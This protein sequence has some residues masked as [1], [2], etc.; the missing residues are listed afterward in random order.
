MK[1]AFRFVSLFLSLLMILTCFSGLT[2]VASAA[3][4]EEI[5]Y[6]DQQIAL[7]AGGQ[8]GAHGSY[9]NGE[10]VAVRYTIPE[11]DT[12]NYFFF[13]A[14]AT[15]SDANTNLK[16]SVYQWNTDYATTVAGEAICSVESAPHAD[17]APLQINVPEGVTVTGEV[18]L[19]L[20][21]SSTEEG[22]Q[23][24]PWA[25]SEGG[26][27]G[28]TYYA[29]GSECSAFCV[30][31]NVRTIES[32]TRNEQVALFNGGQGNPHGAYKN[33]ESVAVRYTIPEGAT[34]NYFFFHAVATY[35]QP[36]TDLKA[37]VYQWNTDY[38]TTV[39]GEALFSV[40][41]KNHADNAPLQIN[42][43]EGVTVTGEILLVLENTSAAEGKTMTPW[44]A[45]EGAADGVTFYANGAEASAFC[46]YANIRATFL[47]QPPDPA[48]SQMESTFT[49]DFGVYSDDPVTDY[50]MAHMNA[51]AAFD[52]MNSG[53]ITFKANGG[54]PWTWL[55]NADMAGFKALNTKVVDFAVI[56][57]RTTA[58]AT[59]EFYVSR[60]DGVS[61]GQAGSHASWNYVPDGQ[62]HTIVVDCSEVWGNTDTKITTLRLDPLAGDVDGK[63]IDIAS[64]TFFSNKA[65]AE[66]YAEAQKVVVPVKG[67]LI[68]GD[69]AVFQIGDSFFTADKWFELIENLV[70]VE[71]V[72]GDYTAM[73]GTMSSDTLF[74]TPVGEGEK[75]LQDGN[76]Q[77]YIANTLGGVISAAEYSSFAVRGWYGSPTE[78]AIEA[79]G[80]AFGDGEPVFSADFIN[81]AE[82]AVKGAAGT[83]DATRYK[84]NIDISGLA[85]GT[86]DV[87]VL[88]KH[89]NGNVFEL[90]N[91]GDIKV[92][93][94]DGKNYQSMGFV[95]AEGNA[96]T[97]ENG[98]VFN[99]EGIDTGLYAA[100]LADGRTVAYG[101]LINLTY[102]DPLAGAVEIDG[103]KYIY[104]QKIQVTDVMVPV[105][106]EDNSVVTSIDVPNVP[107]MSPDTLYLDGTVVKDG[108][109][110]DYIAK[111]LG[112]KIRDTD[113]TMG[114]FS[115]RGWAH[116]G[117]TT[118]IVAYGYALNDGDIIWDAGWVES[119]T[120]VSNVFPNTNVMRYMI[121]ID[122]SSLEEG[123]YNVYLYMKLEDESIYRLNVWGDFQFVKGGTWNH[124]G[125]T[126]G[127]NTYDADSLIYT[128]GDTKYVLTNPKDVTDGLVAGYDYDTLIESVDIDF[129]T[130]IES[131]NR[132]KELTGMD[133]LTTWPAAGYDVDGTQMMAMYGDTSYVLFSSLPFAEYNTVEIVIGT[134]TGVAKNIAVGFISD[135]TQ[136]YGMDVNNLNLTANIAYGIAGPASEGEPNL[137][138]RGNGGGWNS[139]ERLI[140]I[141]IGDIDYDGEVALSISTT[142][143][144]IAVITKLSFANYAT[145][146][147]KGKYIYDET[148]TYVASP[149]TPVNPHTLKPVYIVDGEAL[150]T[151]GG[152]RVEDAVYDYEKGC[153]RYTATD[154]DPNSTSNLVP[155]GTQIGRYLVVKYR[156][157]TPASGE[158]FT[159]VGAGASG[160]S[161]VPF[162]DYEADGQ[163]HYKVV[164]LSRSGDMDGTYVV[165][166]F[167]NDFVQGGGQWLEVEYYAF[168]NTVEEAE[169]YAS[170]DMHV[171]PQPPKYFTATFVADGEV[172]GTIEFKEGTTKLTGIPK[173]PAK[174][175]YTGAW[176]EYTLAD[177]DITINAVYTA[178]QEETVPETQ[179]GGEE[180]EAPK[181]QF[182]SVAHLTGFFKDAHKSYVSVEQCTPTYNE[183]GSLTL[184]G[185]WKED[186]GTI[187]P[188]VS[189]TYCQLMSKNYVNYGAEYG[190]MSKLPNAN[191]EFG[192]VVLKV[193]A[194]AAC[195]GSDLTL[196]Y[197][198][199]RTRDSSYVYSEKAL[200]GNGEFEYVLFDLTDED[201][202]K[203]DFINTLKI[204]WISDGESTAENVGAS[205]TIYDLYLFAD[206]AAA[207]AALE[208]QWPEKETKPPKQTTAE[209]VTT[210]PE[211]P[212][213]EGEETTAETKEG[214]KSV[215]AASGS[216]ALLLVAG[217][218]FVAT[219]K[220]KED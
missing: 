199:G 61:M 207:E 101:H 65:A 15:Y 6:K 142:D 198:M 193:K 163:W 160:G 50:G 216:I 162:G 112:G 78:G 33:G 31:V 86:Y 125:Y 186:A 94:G 208:I 210:A 24:T 68:E 60:A 29:N 103:R 21:N 203:S 84:I 3:G 42:V 10:S 107:A 106:P 38:A 56:K 28:V 133:V 156:T 113:K 182:D 129:A 120:S 154:N 209:P 194:D 96:Y 5:Q 14:V 49:I 164:D 140:R 141:N 54:D 152:Q 18:L 123:I 99:A 176:E 20:E 77:S 206:K 70:E 191:G 87:S 1:K 85:S 118:P 220:K 157:E 7:F 187:N 117:S 149:K 40:E 195:A 190:E 170:H 22:K 158:C 138:G 211:A 4:D 197:I 17:N 55:D 88:V 155:A 11:G 127:T 83:Q 200:V 53:Y 168:F 2:I 69:P 165:N 90:I 81:A 151:N 73:S 92:V 110:H 121:S 189:F 215:V 202:F 205:L 116:T 148:L 188:S 48:E 171:L 183:D 119:D 95:D 19:V 214:C 37:T 46:V 58:E 35:G 201:I 109:A 146:K 143:G 72:T 97:I 175:G 126:D 204:T 44:G 173:V 45:S 192:V 66:A 23:M 39:A 177:A 93:V 145:E 136:L 185:N 150:N 172:V 104:D 12:L 137:S 36:D 212:T 108:G 41:D 161:N 181:G 130:A 91:W 79:Y 76:A 180:T 8:G 75:T 26:V 59:G 124:I 144:N 147:V 16:A 178:K 32:I 179:P 217:A 27:E 102:Q 169:Y 166:H 131:A 213:G 25:A 30:Y 71:P 174:E 51:L 34:L 218:A 139:T 52:T 64:I 153:I 134:D 111:V 135:K 74:V 114:S 62:W 98:R 122:V 47:P 89:T 159:G 167:R 115:V 67:E 105:D 43:P 128:E 132:N 184:T 13:H 219:K 196:T 63:E 57:Y 9:K 82:D 100:T 80:Y